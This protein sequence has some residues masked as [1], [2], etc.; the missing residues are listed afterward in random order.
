MN[1]RYGF[2][3]LIAFAISNAAN[4]ELDRT[5]IGW[6]ILD[7]SKVQEDALGVTRIVTLENGH[8]YKITGIGLPALP[9][10]ETILLGQR[11]DQ[12][13]MLAHGFGPLAKQFPNGI[14]LLKL[15]IGDWVY[16]AEQLR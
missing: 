15:V 5:L 6:T 3:G 10:T 13:N 7:V 16:D 4:A 8:K 14:V 9:F 11:Y 2:I 1:W 12:K